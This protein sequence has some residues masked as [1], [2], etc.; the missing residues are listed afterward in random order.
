MSIPIRTSTGALLREEEAEN[1]LRNKD[2][3]RLVF[4]RR[5][6]LKAAILKDTELPVS[7]TKEG[8]S[9]MQEL[10]VGFVWALRGVE[11]SV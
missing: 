8:T 1:I 2:H 11:G 7:L 3:F 4:N 5:G 6:N 10:S 9:F